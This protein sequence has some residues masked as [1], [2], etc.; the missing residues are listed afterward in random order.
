MWEKLAREW[1]QLGVSLHKGRRREVHLRSCALIG[2]G[3]A[4]AC[5]ALTALNFVQHCGFVTVTTAVFCLGGLALAFSAIRFRKTT[6]ATGALLTMC[7][8]AFTYYGVAGVNEGFSVLWMLVV[9][10]AFCYFMN[11]RAGIVLALYYLAFI[12]VLFYTPAG[13]LVDGF[14]SDTF[15]N[16]F[17]LL[18]ALY[19]FMMSIA[20]V[21]Y[22]QAAMSAIEY[23]AQLEGEVATQTAVAEQRA[24]KIA[25]LSVELVEALAGA[26]DAKDVYTNG[27]SLRVANY[28]ALLAAELGF[29][30]FEVAEVRR[31]GLLH[32]VGKIGIPDDVLNKPGALTDEEREVIRS[33]T[34]KGEN[35]L[36]CVGDL[37]DAARVA[38]WHHER[39]DGG[40]YPDGLAGTAIPLHA[41][42]VAV[43]DSYDAMA[44]KRVYSNEVDTEAIR[45]ELASCRGT[46]FDPRCLDAFLRLLD[47]GALE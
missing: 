31:A 8:I 33:H 29:P 4:I 47:A 24:E 39:F 32:D 11:V 22:H 18:Y 5:G 2:I 3:V 42:I 16:R 15:M 14:Y 21:R 10:L 36:S 26:I 28:S 23:E 41:R 1:R 17:P 35:I 34:L 37:E 9:P 43:A 38:R 46:Q 13:A 7:A 40:G 27:H 6:A 25:G 12:V 30:E 20:M 45:A 44:S 19:A